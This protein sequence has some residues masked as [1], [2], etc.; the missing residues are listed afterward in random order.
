MDSFQDAGE[1]LMNRRNIPLASG[2]LM[3]PALV[4]QNHLPSLI[5]QALFLM[6]LQLLLG[7]RIKILPNLVMLLSITTLNLFQPFGRI[8]V[9][10]FSLP[11]TQGALE[12]GFRRSFTLIGLIYLSRFMV[13]SRPRFPGRLGRLLSL[14]FTYYEGFLTRRVSLRPSVIVE[15]LDELLCELE[16]EGGSDEQ[17]VKLVSLP[18]TAASV[19][20]IWA[21]YFAQRLPIW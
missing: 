18:A 7:R 6:L 15:S 19:V 1:Q 5:I 17:P 4:F 11:V 3:L 8:L 21:L 2:L 9:T 10:L 14:Q 13:I 16:R 12:L 20:F